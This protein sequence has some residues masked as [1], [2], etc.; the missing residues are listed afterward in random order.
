[1]IKGDA[2]VMPILKSSLRV[3]QMQMPELLGMLRFK[4][5]S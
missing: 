1:M 5:M 4:A 3:V 2:R